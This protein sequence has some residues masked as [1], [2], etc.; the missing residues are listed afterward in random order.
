M[1]VCDVKLQI[2]SD[3]INNLICIAAGI[4]MREISLEIVMVQTHILGKISCQL[5][6][7]VG[8]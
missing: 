6:I 3:G 7:A 4:W 5:G 1:G 2:F 8:S